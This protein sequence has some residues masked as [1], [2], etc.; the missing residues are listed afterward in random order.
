MAEA[1]VSL[2][3]GMAVPYNAAMVEKPAGRENT[4]ELEVE[5]GN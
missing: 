1:A 2:A 3:L 4:I 5:F